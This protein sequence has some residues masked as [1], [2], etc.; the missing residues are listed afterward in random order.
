MWLKKS[1]A[2]GIRYRMNKG[3]VVIQGIPAALQL[4]RIA[5]PRID[6]DAIELRL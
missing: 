4:T 1:S 5:L 2:S 6:R 3:S